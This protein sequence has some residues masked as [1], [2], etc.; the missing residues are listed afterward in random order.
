MLCFLSGIAVPGDAP[1]FYQMIQTPDFGINTLQNYPT[2]AV[3]QRTNLITFTTDTPK[4]Y[5][6]VFSDKNPS[7]YLH[8]PHILPLFSDKQRSN[9]TKYPGT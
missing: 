7:F 8:F 9:C 3:S 6:A 5:S 2:R 1:A 4:A